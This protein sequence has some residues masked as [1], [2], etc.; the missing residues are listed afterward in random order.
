MNLAVLGMAVILSLVFG[1]KAYL[2]IQ[3][4]A[5]MTA[6][7]AG[8]WMFYIQHQFEGVYWE[9]GDNW[10]Y[11]GGGFARAVRFTSSPASCNGSPATSAFIISII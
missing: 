11:I 4:I 1:F 6:G 8:V 9:R 5:L 10:S 7:G 2:L 3:L